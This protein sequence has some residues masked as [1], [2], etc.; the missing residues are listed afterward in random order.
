M[1]LSLT[2]TAI[3]VDAKSHG[4]CR[5][6]VTYPVLHL[7]DLLC[8][9]LLTAFGIIQHPLNVTTTFTQ[10]IRDALLAVSRM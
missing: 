3:N 9:L 10:V 4:Q 7:F 1:S 6:H 5:T 2:V 8:K